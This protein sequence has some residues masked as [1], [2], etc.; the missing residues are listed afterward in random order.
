MRRCV[1]RPG[2]HGRMRIYVA[3]RQKADQGDAFGGLKSPEM[4]GL[5]LGDL[6]RTL[7]GYGN[8]R[9]GFCGIVSWRSFDNE[10]ESA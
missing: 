9:G 1:F 6:A 10:V 8:A 3:R 4:K 7:N 5:L 2:M